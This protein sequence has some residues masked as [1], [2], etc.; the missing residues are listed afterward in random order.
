M[1]N[2]YR[3]NECNAN[4]ITHNYNLITAFQ[5]TDN[6]KFI[7]LNSITITLFR[8]ARKFKRGTY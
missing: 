3:E 8:Y 5:L 1:L 6:E 7:I 4:S 2:K